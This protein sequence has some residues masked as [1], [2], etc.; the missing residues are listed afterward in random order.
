MAT[1]AAGLAVATAPWA[2]AGPTG[3]PQISSTCAGKPMESAQPGLDIKSVTMSTTGRTSHRVVRHKRVT[4]YTPTTLV[5]R[6]TLCGPVSSVPGVNYFVKADTSAC[7]NGNFQYQYRTAESSLPSELNSGDLFVTGCGKPNAGTT[8]EFI[9]DVQATVAGATI[10]WSLPL[11]DLGAD[12]PLGSTFTNFE[13]HSDY[14]DPWVGEIGTWFVGG[15]T[16]GAAGVLDYAHSD[17]VWK[18][19]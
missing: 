1:L 2:H 7:G 5:T 16:G 11:A 12:L 6:M 9:S 19:H 13:A 8:S 4:V 18:L 17:V 14:D 15:S 3:A 10:T